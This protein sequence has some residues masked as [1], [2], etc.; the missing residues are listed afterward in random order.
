MNR[1]RT[2]AVQNDSPRSGA[3]AGCFREP[4]PNH[5][6]LVGQHD[7]FFYGSTAALWDMQNPSVGGA[8]IDCLSSENV[9]LSILST[10]P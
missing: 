4:G 7:H 1:L 2:Y 3:A 6:L 10:R 5:F 9:M 8:M